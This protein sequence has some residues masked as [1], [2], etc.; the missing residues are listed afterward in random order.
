MIPRI[1]NFPLLDRGLKK[2]ACKGRI[3]GETPT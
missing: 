2:L 1:V 3:S